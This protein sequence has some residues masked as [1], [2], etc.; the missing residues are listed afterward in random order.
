MGGGG[1]WDYDYSESALRKSSKS[2][3]TEAKKEGVVRAYTGDRG[4]GLP[5]PVGKQISS[6]SPTPVVVAV[7]VTGSM[8]QWPGIIFEKLPVLYG[9]A[10]LHLP[11]VD[12]SFCAIGDANIDQYPLQICDFAK[13]KRLEEHINSLFP[14]GGGG[15]GIKESYELAAYFYARHCQLAGAA[16]AL[17]VFCGDEG[18]Y[19]R[20]KV[21]SV[22]KLT[23]D[24][25]TADLD[26]YDI[27]AELG[28]RFDVYMLRVPYDDPVKDEIIHEQWQR[29]LGRQTVLR[30]EDPRRIVDCII[31]LAAIQAEEQDSFSARLAIRQTPAQVQQVMS[32]LHPLMGRQG[33]GG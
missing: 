21:G 26:S 3:A 25:P 14:E 10:R 7:D 30:M 32:T 17:F 20:I 8:G 4:K 6:S 12:L 23:G 2:Y 29:A 27:F 18:F 31:G 33:T 9:E 11:D 15:G 5:P 1:G 19:E 24:A 28:R 13:G 22:R 16:R